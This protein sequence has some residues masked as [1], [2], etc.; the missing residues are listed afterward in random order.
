MSISLESIQKGSA[1]FFNLMKE[2]IIPLEDTGA[3]EFLN[4]P[5]IR[6]VVKT[7][8][9][10][11][12]MTVFNTRENIHLVTNSYGSIF[13]SSYTQM[14]E[15]YSGLKRKKYFYLANIIICVFLAEVDKESHVRVR[16]EEE[17]VSYA[18]LEDLVTNTLNSWKKR[19]E[20][21]ETFSKD[22]GIALEEIEELW[23]TTF[24]PFKVSNVN[25]QI[26]VTQTTGNRYSFI[27]TAL[28]PL[29]D[30]KLIINNTSELKIIP[31][32]ELYERLDRIYHNKE[33]YRE[34]ISLIEK[35]R[36]E[37]K[38]EDIE[39][40]R[41]KGTRGKG[42]IMESRGEMEDAEVN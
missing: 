24:S 3:Q 41:K 18:K 19:Q 20:E 28:K 33:R 12:G 32:N 8:A 1:L 34:F 2:K 9:A 4:N 5:E 16:W 35:T 30:Q 42:E 37:K 17:G 7:M 39:E 15:K 31:K 23:N 14:K 6:E 22:W 13:A 25:D 38:K 36:E 10:E 29:A 21:E 26:N 40:E 11:A 27:Y